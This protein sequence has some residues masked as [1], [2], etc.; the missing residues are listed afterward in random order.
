MKIL[1]P[2]HKDS[3]PSMEI[4]EDS[5]YCF[6]CSSVVPIEELDVEYIKRPPT[7]IA[8][9]MEYIDGLPIQAVRG[10]ALP[11]DDKGYYITWPEKNYYRLRFWNGNPRY[12]GPRGHKPPLLTYKKD[13]SIAVLVEGEINAIS[14]QV[15]NIPHT[16]ASF[17]SAANAK[18]YINEYLQYKTIYAIFDKDGPGLAYG[19]ELREM[20]MG[21]SKRVELILMETD[22]NDI[23]V[24]HGVEG[25][26]EK[27]KKDLGM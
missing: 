12:V 26:R 24:K 11:T 4:Y 15:C 18:S 16:I 23:L 8:E 10:L 21:K 1:C 17:G 27:A 14:L 20:L 3:N 6:V 5:G 2:K 19:L 7:S 13:N 22:Y 9:M 25:V